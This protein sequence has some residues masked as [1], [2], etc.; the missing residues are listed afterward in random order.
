[1][2]FTELPE[3]TVPSEE[4][5]YQT[6]LRSLR[7]RKGF[8]IVFVQ[9]SPS[10]ARRLIERIPKDLPQ[11]CI[12]TLQLVDPID[13]LYDLI[14]N[15]SDRNRL[16]I[17]FILGLEKSL[18]AYVKPGYGGEGDYYTLD[19]VP[20]ILSHLNQRREIFRDHFNNICFVFFLPLFAIKYF[21]RRAPDFFDWSAGIFEF[22][23]NIEILEQ[24]IQSILAFPKKSY[25]NLTDEEYENKML[26]VEE[27]IE[28]A[29]ENQEHLTDLLFLKGFLFSNRKYY[30][31]AID[32]YERAIELD[33][34]RAESWLAQ[35]D[36]FYALHRYEDAIASYDKSLLLAPHNPEG[37]IKKG[38]ALR[39]VGRFDE[40]VLNYQK[41]LELNPNSPDVDLRLFSTE[42]EIRPTSDEQE[43]LSES[44]LSGKSK[45]ILQFLFDEL[46]NSTKA[47]EQNCWSVA[48]RL[49]K[50]VI[51]ICD[52]SERIRAS[53]NVNLWIMTLARNRLKQCLE[54]YELGRRRARVELH[55]TL[56][57]IA[58][59]H[60]L[61]SDSQPSYQARYTLIE[62]F[63]QGFYIET[64][65]AF[66][67][68]AQLPQ[69]YRP[70]T[71]L[72]LS[73][74]MSF[75]ERYAKRRILLP[76][77]HSQQLIVL[78]AQTFSQQQFE[79]Q[80]SILKSKDELI[81]MQN[82]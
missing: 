12:S 49:S 79:A 60:I 55:S 34:N 65:N 11:K 13:N 7:R 43:I 77:R 63:L 66:R 23:A 56:A 38:D 58:Y 33:P 16:N 67:R 25:E 19:T 5:V 71:L 57:A 52:Q 4:E 70:S 75:T 68:E 80:E 50:E 8:G 78:R 47:S 26:E 73:E 69:T 2:S 24:Q 72:E 48:E 30:E 44:A 9:C 76:G 10:E 64:L 3:H 62:D 59:R 22:P 15:R 27:L 17:L 82:E 41:A 35:G 46:R 32:I 40:A 14:A 39:K 53:G 36:A 29:S 51:H 20:R 54:Y 21:I 74:Y 31:R 37:L 1:M 81:D 6:L 42:Q 28:T 45:A 18:E 61:L